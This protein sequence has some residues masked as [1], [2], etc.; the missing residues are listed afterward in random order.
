MLCFNNRDLFLKLAHY[1]VSEIR[2][3]EKYRWLSGG[4][5]H[6]DFFHLFVNMFVLWSFGS[7]VEANFIQHKGEMVGKILY[8]TFYLFMVVLANLPTYAKYKNN[9]S[10]MAVGASGATNAVLFSAIF[11]S[12]TSNIYLYLALPIPAI[13]FGVLYL[14]YSHW[15]SKRGQDNIDH[16]AHIY[17]AIAGFVFTALLFPNL[18]GDFFYKLTTWF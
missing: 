7:N 16:E 4:F 5:V 14:W 17:G 8:L 15:A 13:L 1:P 12:P 6:S 3:N 11:F 2:N 18:I 10:Y 9:S